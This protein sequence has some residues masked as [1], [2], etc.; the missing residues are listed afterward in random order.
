MLFH[1]QAVCRRGTKWKK[2]YKTNVDN[3]AM[4]I[5]R[6]QAVSEIMSLLFKEQR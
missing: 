5:A 2:S 3:R 1:E 4:C 6:S